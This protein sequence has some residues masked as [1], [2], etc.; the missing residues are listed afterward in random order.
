MNDQ[1]N[2]NYENNTY[3]REA[4]KKALTHL[5]NFVREDDSAKYVIDPKNV[6]CRK[7]D[8]ADKVSCLKL[9]ELDEKEIF[10]QM[11]K[12]GF[13]CALAQDPNNI[14]LECNKVQ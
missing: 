8:N 2:K 5:E 12:L 14:G 7:N 6:V 1:E 11:Q 3:S 9:N 4:K 13:Y 10:S